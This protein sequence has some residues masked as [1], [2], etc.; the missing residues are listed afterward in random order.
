MFMF[1]ANSDQSISQYNLNG[2]H[3]IEELLNFVKHE[4]N[5]KPAFSPFINQADDAAK[6]DSAAEDGEGEVNLLDRIR[7]ACTNETDV[8]EEQIDFIHSEV[9]RAFRMFY[10]KME[11]ESK[12]KPYKEDYFLWIIYNQLITFNYLW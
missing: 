11:M 12:L 3:L 5:S 8:K 4:F 7:Y 1:Y 6:K 10:H 9:A 2:K